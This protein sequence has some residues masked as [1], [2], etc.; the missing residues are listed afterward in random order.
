[1]SRYL[2]RTSEGIEQAVK[3]GIKIIRVEDERLYSA[4]ANLAAYSNGCVKTFAV[5]PVFLQD[6]L[7]FDVSII[8]FL[9]NSHTQQTEPI[10]VQREAE[11]PR[12]YLAEALS[13]YPNTISFGCGHKIEATV[14]DI[15]GLDDGT[16][17]SLCPTSMR[18]QAE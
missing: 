16:D 1:M 2:Y 18:A 3:K 14:S 15:E 5:K 7:V 9:P 11:A 10:N 4:M 12:D 8:D 13:L 17:L 6:G